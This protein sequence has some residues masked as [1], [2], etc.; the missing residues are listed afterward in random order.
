MTNLNNYISIKEI[1]DN[2]MR[3]PATKDLDYE[4]AI[5]WTLD[6]MGNIG[7]YDLY[8]DEVS[9]IEIVNNRGK[10]PSGLVRI[11]QIRKLTGSLENPL[12]LSMTVA[13][14]SFAVSY[15][16]YNKNYRSTLQDNKY[17]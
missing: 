3:Y 7:S 9:T 2:L 15:R 10:L 1:I 17:Y 8:K 4:S 5:A 12:Y 14:D 16:K 11:D 13:S 6:V